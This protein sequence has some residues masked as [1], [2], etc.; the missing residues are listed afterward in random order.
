MDKYDAAIAY[1]TE[2]PDRILDAWRSPITVKGGC[3]FQL[4]SKT[5]EYPKDSVEFIGC[6]T[7]IRHNGPDRIIAVVED[8][9]DLTK[10]IAEDIRIPKNQNTIKVSDLH[11][12]AEW[13]RRLDVELGRGE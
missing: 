4:A 11:V 9:P 8:R 6:L 1:L 2:H 7:Q 13:Q 10:A 3:L 5:A 12:F